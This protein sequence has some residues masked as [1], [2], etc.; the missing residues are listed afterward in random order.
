MANVNVTYEDLESVAGQIDSGKDQLTT[1]LQQLQSIVDN[2]T[3]SGFQTE[4]ASG[5][6]QTHFRDYVTKTTGA[7]EALQAYSQFLRTSA[8]ALRDTDTGLA[9]QLNG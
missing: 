6:Y 7:I 5:A 1:Q 3:S 2:L 8:Q 9:S 4:H